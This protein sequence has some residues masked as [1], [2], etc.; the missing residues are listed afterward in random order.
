[1]YVV[2]VSIQVKDPHVEAFVAATLENARH[3][4]RESGNVRYDVLRHEQEP[5]RFTLVEAYRE[6]GDFTRHQQTPHYL[7]WKQAVA[8]WMAVPRVGTRHV[9][10]FPAD[11]EW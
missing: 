7:A 4:R 1:M 10:V 11:A 5:A 8:D 3:T 9:S 6:P 2:C